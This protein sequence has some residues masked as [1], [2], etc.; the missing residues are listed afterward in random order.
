[1]GIRK[2]GWFLIIFVLLFT[3]ACTQ[4]APPSNEKITLNVWAW[5]GNYNRFA[6]D[7]MAKNPNIRLQ[8]IEPFEQSH[9]DILL[10]E[11]IDFES[12]RKQYF[13]ALDK[14]QPDV[15]LL[16][17][18][19]TYHT[20]AST[21]K[22]L[23]LESYI[24]KEEFQ[25]ETYSQHLIEMLRSTGNGTLFAVAVG[26]YNEALFYNK[27]LL[28]QYGVEV[29]EAGL[30]WEAMLDITK[31]LPTGPEK[32]DIHGYFVG[33]REKPSTSWSVIKNIGLSRGLKYADLEQKKVTLNTESWQKI[34]EMVLE[35][36]KSGAMYEHIEKMPINPLSGYPD[37]IPEIAYGPFFS[38]KSAF[39]IRSPYF[40]EVLKKGNVPFEWGI[41]P[42]PIDSKM[43]EGVSMSPSE[44][45]AINVAS[46][47]KE[48]AWELLNYLVSEERAKQLAS[49]E[50]IMDTLPARTN[51]VKSN[52][53]QFAPFYALPPSQNAFYFE[54]TIPPKF[55]EKVSSIALKLFAELM[56]DKLT[57]AEALEKLQNE[58]QVEMNALSGS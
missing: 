41:V 40:I 29:P 57:V 15:I 45:Y 35:G 9:K 49:S 33:T 32:D 20:L 11:N 37:I 58:A 17:E 54:G 1:M 34:W 51:T 24:E 18:S 50:N 31:L 16:T 52:D 10:N 44:L 23:S 46:G 43:A 56:E 28:Q 55:S 48:E 21:G 39:S 5:D 26:F 47:H 13:E 36:Y 42:E 25:K 38:G 7:F 4:K 3:Q 22:L 14:A 6:A 30:S 19:S 2:F 12:Y 8:W 27:T 53:P